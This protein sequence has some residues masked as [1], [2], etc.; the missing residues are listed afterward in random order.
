MGYG[1]SVVG[2][3]YYSD[4][5]SAISVSDSTL[6]ARQNALHDY[7][8]RLSRKLTTVSLWSAAAMG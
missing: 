8:M 3:R 7:E 2:R 4:E 5:W 6:L 1:L